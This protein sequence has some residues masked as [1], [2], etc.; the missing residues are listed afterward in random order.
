MWLS[1]KLAENS[2]SSQ[3]NIAEIG[4]LSIATDNVVAAVSSSEKR[5]I[6]FYAPY[7]IE[8]FPEENQDV[9]LITCG[10]RTACAG[11]E[12]KKTSA[13]SAGEVRVFSHGGANLL[14][15]NDGSIVL[16][17]I[18]TIDKSGNIRT[19][20]SVTAAAFQDLY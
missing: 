17:N 16:N 9:L 19:S 20:G 11:V 8:F 4:T 5:G 14:L 2:A 7:G 10:N 15:K 6:V 1:K 3:E 12:M 18:V 13:I